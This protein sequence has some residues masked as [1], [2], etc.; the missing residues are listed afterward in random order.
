[1]ATASSGSSGAS[2]TGAKPD[3]IIRSRRSISASRAS[4][5]EGSGIVA[6]GTPARGVKPKGSNVGQLPSSRAA[7]SAT[8]VGVRPTD[9][10]LLRS[11]SAL[12]SA[13]PEEP[14][15]IAPAWPMVLPGGAVK[16][17]M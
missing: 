11:A 1:M 7:S 17:A 3:W 4:R 14:E 8:W 13:P 15:T 12:A 9:T 10:P 16:P 5:I 2:C 6:K